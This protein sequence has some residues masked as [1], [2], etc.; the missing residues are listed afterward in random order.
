MSRLLFGSVEEAGASGVIPINQ[1]GSRPAR[2][3]AMDVNQA[4]GPYNFIGVSE[5]SRMSVQVTA[6]GG[7]ATFHLEVTNG[8]PGDEDVAWFKLEST[9]ALDGSTDPASDILVAI[10]MLYRYA[11]VS[12]SDA[13]GDPNLNVILL[14]G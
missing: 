14:A 3:S 5:A 9:A 8:N 4:D 1:M 13:T 10:D 6:D 11:R 7:S 2:V 12:W